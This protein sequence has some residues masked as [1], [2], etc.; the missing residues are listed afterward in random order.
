MLPPTRSLFTSPKV[1]LISSAPNPPL[2][3]PDALEE[4]KALSEPLPREM[5]V[6]DPAREAISSPLWRL[7]EFRSEKL[8]PSML[9]E[10]LEFIIRLLPKPEPI[11]L[12]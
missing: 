10:W 7:I 11:T 1:V 4:R 12:T 6:K 3:V 5:S 2:I 8:K 9:P